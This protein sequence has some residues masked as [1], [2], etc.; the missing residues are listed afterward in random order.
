MC[1]QSGPSGLIILIISPLSAFPP[2]KKEAI[3]R[4]PVWVNLIKKN[5]D[6]GRD[7]SLQMS[8]LIRG[9]KAAICEL[10]RLLKWVESACCVCES[11][12]YQ[13]KKKRKKRKNIF[14]SLEN[15]SFLPAA[16]VDKLSLKRLLEPLPCLIRRR[17]WQRVRQNT[18]RPERSRETLS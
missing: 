12:L 13:Q 18:P 9:V 17:A 6:G 1:A 7:E 14:P 16:S 3:K 11:F 4:M 10:G 8:V 2:P 5:Q 15:T